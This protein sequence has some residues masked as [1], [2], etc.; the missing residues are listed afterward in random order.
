MDMYGQ[1]FVIGHVKPNADSIFSSIGSAWLIK[2][3]AGIEIIAAIVG[4]L[5]F[6]TDWLLNFIE[7][8]IPALRSKA[9]PRFKSVAKMI[10]V[11]HPENHLKGAQILCAGKV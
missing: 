7:G 6:Q 10:P 4:I 11:V 8:G 2:E 3:H 5:G 9:S 1:T